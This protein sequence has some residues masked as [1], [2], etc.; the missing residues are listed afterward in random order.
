ML[1]YWQKLNSRPVEKKTNIEQTIKQKKMTCERVA[2][3]IYG[4]RCGLINKCVNY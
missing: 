3:K 1:W 4:G 2:L